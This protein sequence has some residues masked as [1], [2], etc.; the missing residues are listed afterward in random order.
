MI[1]KAMPASSTALDSEFADARERDR[2]RQSD[3]ALVAYVAK[4][5]RRIGRLQKAHPERWR[6]PG[7]SPEEVRD[8]LTLTLVEAIRA[9]GDD[10]PVHARAGREWGL[11]VALDRLAELRG[12]FRLEATPV[13]FRE[14]PALRQR[15]PTLEEQ[16]LEHEGEACRAEAREGAERGLS[17][18]QRRWY[19][20]MRLAARGG[21]FFETSDRLNLSAA[22]RILGKNR[23]S[24][25]RAY[26]ELQARFAEEL[27]KVE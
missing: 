13:D 5:E 21:E 16:W 14:P 12:A 22:A 2:A 4:W 15:E 25:Q 18:P 17:K 27:E 11:A 9:E 26:S 19:A 24:A 23:S 8:A 7:L 6:V 1:P 20:A 10:P 3:R